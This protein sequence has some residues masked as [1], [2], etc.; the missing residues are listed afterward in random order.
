MDF[1]AI[2]FETANPQATSACA[3]GLAVVRQGVIVERFARL[4]RPTPNYYRFTNIHGITAAMTAQAPTF[5]ELWPQLAPLLQGQ[6]LVA[7]NKRFDS[8]VLANTLA[9]YGIPMPEAS[10]HCT[11]AISRRVLPT[12][13]NHRLSTVCAHLGIPLNHHEAESDAV[14]AACI[15]LHALQQLQ[16]TSLFELD[17]KLATLPAPPR[18]PF[19]RWR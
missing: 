19:R 15:A 6:P 9:H 18:R 1:V 14:G 4:I 12:L 5:A 2:D 7:H 10:W 13:P 3:I 11:V 16:A 8:G 17:T